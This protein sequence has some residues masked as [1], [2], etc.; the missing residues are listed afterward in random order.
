MGDDSPRFNANDIQDP[1]QQLQYLACEAASVSLDE[2][3]A[4]DTINIGKALPDYLLTQLCETFYHKIY[5]DVSPHTEWFRDYFCN[6]T[7]EESTQD[8]S[9]YLSQRLG[10]K[11]YYSARRGLPNLICHHCRLGLT[12]RAAEKW[13]E[14]MGDTLDEMDQ[15]IPDRYSDKLRDFFRFTAFFLVIAG[16]KMH[17]MK[18]KRTYDPFP[19]PIIPPPE[20][21]DDDD[22]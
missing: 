8:L 6:K 1:I 18:S 7:C 15:D 17:S 2:A 21:E 11:A 5:D 10:G 20:Q 16:E 22:F 19:E 12:E 3:F 4:I 9:E 14:Y 13:C